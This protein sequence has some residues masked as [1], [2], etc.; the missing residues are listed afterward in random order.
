MANAIIK[1]SPK[2]YDRDGFV[3]VK[4]VIA[5]TSLSKT[6]I[7]AEIDAGRLIAYS[8]CGKHVLKPADVERW[9]LINSFKI[10][11]ATKDVRIHALQSA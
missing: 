9:A 6:K 7:Y 1:F 4:Q 2:E 11:G 10:K 3:S 8:L 5:K